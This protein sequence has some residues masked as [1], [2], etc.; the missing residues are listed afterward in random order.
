MQDV[1]QRSF[2]FFFVGI[3]QY[4]KRKWQS[5]LA[6]IKKVAIF[7]NYMNKKWQNFKK[8]NNFFANIL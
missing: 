1:C 3:S 8:F 2:F 7:A 6:Y 4:F 5:L